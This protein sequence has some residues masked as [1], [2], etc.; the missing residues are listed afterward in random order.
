MELSDILGAILGIASWAFV[1]Y[2][3]LTRGLHGTFDLTRELV[4]RVIEG[5]PRKDFPEVKKADLGKIAILETEIYGEVVSPSLKSTY[6]RTE[7]YP[8]ECDFSLYK[9]GSYT[10]RCVICNNPEP[11]P[12]PVIP[13]R[14]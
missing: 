12:D 9:L 2:L 1:I 13:T 3:I 14:E 6:A 11:L 4:E 8:H 5:P 10:A 7:V